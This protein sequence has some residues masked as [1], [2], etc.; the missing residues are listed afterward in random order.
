MKKFIEIEQILLKEIHVFLTESKMT[1]SAFGGQACNDP[2]IVMRL[3][4]GRE[5]RSGTIN[6]IRKYIAD[7]TPL[8]EDSAT[9]E[10]EVYE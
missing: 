7:N 8:K 10:G 4:E 1:P 2:K 5:L 3:K 9:K 6:K